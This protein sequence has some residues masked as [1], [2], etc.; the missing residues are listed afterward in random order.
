[1][2][3]E[4]NLNQGRAMEDGQYRFSI[5]SGL[6]PDG[7]AVS[8]YGGQHRGWIDPARA[9]TTRLKP[10]AMGQYILWSGDGTP[11]IVALHPHPAWAGVPLP[12]APDGREAALELKVVEAKVI[13]GETEV[14][15]ILFD[16][17]P[18]ALSYARDGQ[19]ERIVFDTPSAPSATSEIASAY[20]V[21]NVRLGMPLAEAE[22]AA[23]AFLGSDPERLEWAYA[24]ATLSDAV[25]LRNPAAGGGWSEMVA[26]FYDKTLPDKPLIAVGRDLRGFEHGDTAMAMEALLPRLEEKFGK[27]APGHEPELVYWAADAVTK[28]VLDAGIDYND[29]CSHFDFANFAFDPTGGGGG[30]FA[31]QSPKDCGEML[32]LTVRSEYV[33]QFLTNTSLFTP[34]LAREQSNAPE[35]QPGAQIKF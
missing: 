12:F 29:G 25:V 11:A 18:V 19:T 4:I 26:L 10:N 28:A 8:G 13:T 14:P 17:L 24:N 16:V 31:R 9:A 7:S 33:A 3:D 6:E 5:T 34:K 32:S 30:R 21:A 1:V 35:A 20:N 2:I 27:S 22:A 15:F 23:R